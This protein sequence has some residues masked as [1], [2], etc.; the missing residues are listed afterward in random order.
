MSKS[1]ADTVSLQRYRKSRV[2]PQPRHDVFSS[3]M[4]NNT[5]DISCLCLRYRIIDLVVQSYAPQPNLI[6][7]PVSL[8][9]FLPQISSSYLASLAEKVN[10]WDFHA[11]RFSMED[12]IWTSVLIL[13]HVLATGGP[14]LT[15]YH[16][17]RGTQYH[18][19][20]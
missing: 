17:T 4:Q 13:E 1:L 16:A 9:E 19:I 20:C 14:D 6:R 12:L 15:R 11:G 8:E 3:W 18:F 7:R 5:F 10:D 2:A